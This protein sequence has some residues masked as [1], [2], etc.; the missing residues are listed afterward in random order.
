MPMM[1]GF[2]QE[3]RRLLEEEFLRVAGEMTPLGAQRLYLAGDLA[4]DRVTRSSELALVIV[5]E[6]EVPAHRRAEFFVTH[7][8]PRVGTRFHVYTPAEFDA[9]AGTDPLL[10][11]TLRVS[12]AIDVG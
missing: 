5:Q 3:R 12:D 7:L 11:S 10:R 4:H 1:F 2:A 6:T 9:R 8:R